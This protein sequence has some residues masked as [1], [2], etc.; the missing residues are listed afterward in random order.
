[1][2]KS[3]DDRDNK[4]TQPSLWDNLDLESGWDCLFH[5]DFDG[6]I[7]Y[8]T[9]SISGFVNPTEIDYALNTTHFWKERIENKEW[10]ENTCHS[11]LKDFIEYYFEPSCKLLEVNLINFIAD[12][13]IEQE[14]IKREKKEE[15]FDLLLQLKSTD[16]MINFSQKLIK[17]SPDS[18]DLLY[19]LAQATWHNGNKKEANEIY[20]KALLLAP[21]KLPIKRIDNPELK[22]IIFKYGP[23]MT[24]SY[25]WIYGISPSIEY[26]DLEYLGLKTKGLKCY[27]LLQK[28]HKSI[29][30]KDLSIIVNLRKQLKEEDPELYVAYFDLIKGINIK[31]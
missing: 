6:A 29:E 4:V 21:E 14:N 26:K 2:K 7:D 31:R 11:V 30:S 15:V 16:K 3:A 1:M 20:T 28:A 24:P 27:V 18:F 17:Q 25:S 12:H 22:R 13:F 23:E 10:N 5:L 9:K 19:L 8:F